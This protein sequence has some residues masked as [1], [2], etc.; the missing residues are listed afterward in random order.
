MRYLKTYEGYFEE[1][2]NSNITA[3]VIDIFQD[4][5]ED[6]DFDVTCFTI[7]Y[8]TLNHYGAKHSDNDISL[9]ISRKYQ[10]HEV[11]MLKPQ[12]DYKSFT[13]DEVLPYIKRT[14]E[15]MESEG[16][17]INKISYQYRLQGRRRPGSGKLQQ[18]DIETM[19]ELMKSSYTNFEN[20]QI[21]FGTGHFSTGENVNESQY[22]DPF[23]KS[24]KDFIESNKVKFKSIVD[25]C[26][27]DLTDEYKTLSGF[28]DDRMHGRGEGFPKKGDML[29]YYNIIIPVDKDSTDIYELAYAS[30]FEKQITSCLSKLIGLEA[31]FEVQV[32]Y[33][34]N[35]NWD[36]SGSNISSGHH[37]THGT[38]RFTNLSD[39]WTISK[40]VSSV[41]NSMTGIHSDSRDIF[42][43]VVIKF[44]VW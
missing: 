13:L 19:D 40:M 9:S 18:K 38:E 32:S 42:D 31:H 12:T 27:Y 11:D 2:I 6:S 35:I 43:H 4:L 30:E 5:T 17:P 7:G 26:M 16:K 41:Q 15:Y 22:S 36:R 20:I 33:E 3:T 34:N 21:E 23:N 39:F 29:L 10:K 25:E 44:N 1:D 14:A 37:S 28:E 24:I 8:K